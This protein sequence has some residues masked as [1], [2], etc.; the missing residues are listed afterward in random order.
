[1]QLELPNNDQYDKIVNSGQKQ[2]LFKIENPTIVKTVEKVV[3]D[4]Q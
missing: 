3:T 2:V 4:A 1:M